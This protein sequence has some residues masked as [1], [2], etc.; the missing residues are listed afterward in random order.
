MLFKEGGKRSCETP[1]QSETRFLAAD[2]HIMDGGRPR[3]ID[4]LPALSPH[5]SAPV[6]VLPVHKEAR[7]HGAHV[8]YRR[9]PRQHAGPGD[10]IHFYGGYP[11]RFAG[12]DIFP[13][14]RVIRENLG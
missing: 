7:I 9:S 14:D 5:S 11:I 13:C 3:E 2:A 10:P 4:D 12:Q 1:E 8:F 6:S